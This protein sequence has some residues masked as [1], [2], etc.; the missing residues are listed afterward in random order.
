MRP[1]AHPAHRRGGVFPSPGVW[2]GAPI[3]AQT[4][5]AG[6]TLMFSWSSSVQAEHR[7]C[8]LHTH[9]HTSRHT[10]PLASPLGW[11]P[12]LRDKCSERGTPRCQPGPRRPV[13][14][15]APRA[16]C[17][18]VLSVL[19]A[20][21]AGTHALCSGSR[22]SPAPLLAFCL[23]SPPLGLFLFFFFPPLLYWKQLKRVD[24]L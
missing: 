4:V 13:S 1:C 6:L 5:W 9:T 12:S 24:C 15:C 17:A 19:T 8:T 21:E 20:S 7:V 18:L 22:H 10:L 16:C 14:P 2:G 11:L 23:R 3:A